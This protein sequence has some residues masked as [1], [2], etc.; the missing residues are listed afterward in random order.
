MVIFCTNTNTSFAKRYIILI[1]Q[2]N[3][4]SFLTWNTKHNLKKCNNL[5]LSHALI[6]DFKIMKKDSKL[7][8]SKFVSKS[9]IIILLPLIILFLI[10]YVL[11]ILVRKWLIT[12]SFL[13][14]YG[15][16]ATI[17][18]LIFMG[19]KSNEKLVLVKFVRFTQIWF[20]LKD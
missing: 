16:W 4:I 3:I 6:I 10:I 14:F 9:N 19:L 20:S 8:F 13:T 12:R 1:S 11:F 2:L 18:F 15:P 17:S 5:Y 7:I